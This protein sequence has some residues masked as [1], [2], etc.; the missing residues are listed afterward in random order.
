MDLKCFFYTFVPILNY[1]NRMFCVIVHESE[2]K[3][4]ALMTVIGILTF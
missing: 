2:M 1:C 3:Y 4:T